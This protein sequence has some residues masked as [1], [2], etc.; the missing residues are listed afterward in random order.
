MPVAAFMRTRLTS[1]HVFIRLNP[2]K[3]AHTN[4]HAMEKPFPFPA[5]ALRGLIVRGPAVQC[6]G[7]LVIRSCSCPLTPTSSQKSRLIKANPAKDT[8]QPKNRPFA[9]CHF[10]PLVRG[11]GSLGLVVP[12]SIVPSPR[13]AVSPLE[14]LNFQTSCGQVKCCCI[15]KTVFLCVYLRLAAVERILV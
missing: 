9:I 3:S 2:A 7:G 1:Q 6:A 13:T 5:A 14:S 4:S 15:L 11:P 10:P 12:S 8:T